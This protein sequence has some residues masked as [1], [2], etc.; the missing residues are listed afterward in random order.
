MCK[1]SRR[2]WGLGLNLVFRVLS[3]RSGFAEIDRIAAQDR[4]L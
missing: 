2:R 1:E 4:V 3:G